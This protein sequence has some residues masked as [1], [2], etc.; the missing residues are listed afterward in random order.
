MHESII[1]TSVDSHGGVSPT[2]G[3]ILKECNVSLIYIIH[4]KDDEANLKKIWN[5]LKLLNIAAEERNVADPWMDVFKLVGEVKEGHPDQEILIDGAGGS[6]V[7]NVALTCAAF[8][9]G[10]RAF[11]KYEDKFIL[12][13]VLKF[14]YYNL[15]S[16][17]KMRILQLLAEPN[18][19]TLDDLT[20]GMHMSLSLISYH[21]NGNIKTDGLKGLG[22]VETI[23][24]KGRV[25]IQLTTMG[26]LLLNGY[27]TPQPIEKKKGRPPLKKRR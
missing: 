23:E 2:L 4:E 17:R 16:E 19:N 7:L 13:P 14:D 8:V 5:A 10:L 3:E 26:R 25:R 9:N 20:K 6:P 24:K 22:L 15:L 18:V 21:V 11:G 12:F 27:V 1:I